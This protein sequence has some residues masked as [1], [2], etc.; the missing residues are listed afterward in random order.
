MKQPS[1]CPACAC[2]LAGDRLHDCGID[3]C[4][5]C[6]GFW[7]AESD[8]GRIVRSAAVP[9]TTRP[10]ARAP[11]ADLT[12]PG[13]Q[14]PLEHFE[15]SHDS[16]VMLHRCRDCCGVWLLDGQLAAIARYRECSPA[17]ASLAEAKSRQ[18]QRTRRLQRVRDALRSR[19]VSAAIAIAALLSIGIATR[20]VKVMIVALPMLVLPVAWIWFP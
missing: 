8:L 12:C 3:R 7:I 15:Y 17:V 13:C 14:G 4:A 5:R 19:R 2:Q 9:E 6:D 1:H 18:L 16:S 10:R 20:S 11:I